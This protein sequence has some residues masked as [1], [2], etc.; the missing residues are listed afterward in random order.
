MVDAASPNA[1]NNR[2]MSKK[3]ELLSL[4]D[5]NR[6]RNASIGKCKRH[7]C[8][9]SRTI[10]QKCGQSCG[11]NHWVI[12]YYII[13]YTIYIYRYRVYSK[14]RVLIVE[15]SYTKYNYILYIEYIIIV[16]IVAR[17]R[18][19]VANSD[20]S[21]SLRG[22]FK[23]SININCGCCN[24]PPQPLSAQLD[25]TEKAYNLTLL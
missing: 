22:W 11:V 18:N 17:S 23:S 13:F 12:I 7:G 9:K 25:H 3:P 15:L 4:M 20:K 14:P 2:K 24:S 16:L 19:W 8:I 21:L 5:A 1:N 6:N 10:N